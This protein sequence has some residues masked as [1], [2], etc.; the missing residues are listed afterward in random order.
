MLKV[1]SSKSENLSI[2]IHMT[3]RSYIV[4]LLRFTIIWRIKREGNRE[5]LKTG[6]L[7]HENN[8]TH[9]NFQDSIIKQNKI[10]Q[11]SRTNEHGKS[12]L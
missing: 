3:F 2:R 9:G 8:K 10:L 1:L 7:F 11:K 4:R 5:I 12:M 6:R